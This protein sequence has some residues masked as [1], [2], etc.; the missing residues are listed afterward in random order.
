MI[1][2]LLVL[3][4][5]IAAF[6][7]SALADSILNFNE[8]TIEDALVQTVEEDDFYV[9]AMSEQ[10]DGALGNMS[11]LFYIPKELL[12]NASYELEVLKPDKVMRS[13]FYCESSPKYGFKL[14]SL[15][16]VYVVFQDLS[17][18]G[19]T[20]KVTKFNG[21]VAANSEQGSFAISDLT[22]AESGRKD[23][24]FSFE[25]ETENRSYKYSSKASNENTSCKKA[26]KLSSVKFGK[27]VSQETTNGN[28]FAAIDPQ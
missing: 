12:T 19:S 21:V 27:I 3:A 6:T 15:D 24:L 18:D 14:P 16:K 20:G 11:A 10:L 28:S 13:K 2:R 4:L 22:V 25:V 26:I 7:Q 9:I 5:S 1:K 23:F 8:R 17:L